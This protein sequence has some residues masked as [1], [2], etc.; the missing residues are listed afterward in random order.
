MER[1]EFIESTHTY[2]YDGVIVPSVTQLINYIYPNKFDGVPKDTLLAK[3][4]FGTNIHNAIECYE[5]GEEFK[6]SSMERVVFEQY[7][8]VKER[9]QI[10]VVEQ[11][12]MI[13]YED[14]FAGRLDMI[15]NVRGVRSLVDVKT[16]A[17]IDYDSLSWQLA[18]YELGCD[19][20][21]EKHYVLWLPKKGM[22][23]LVEIKPKTKEE[24]LEVVSSYE[25]SQQSNHG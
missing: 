2:L 16:T 9:E 3:S 1:L 24:V 11:E 7:L 4:K 14:R 13:H 17:K 19:E 12:R 25:K 21:F 6:L 5:K 10:E 18:F 23:R 15:A 8:R 22:G 20:K